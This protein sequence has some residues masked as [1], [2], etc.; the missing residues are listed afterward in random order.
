MKKSKKKILLSAYHY[1]CFFILMAFI[2]TCCMSLFLTTMAKAINLEFSRENIKTAAIYTFFNVVFLSFLCTLIDAIRRKL[3]VDRPVKQIVEAAEKIA[4]GDYSVRIP[5]LKSLNRADGLDQIVNCYNKMAEELAGTETMRTDFI[6][7]VSHELK[8]PLAVMQNY[9]TLLQQENIDEEERLKYAKEITNATRRLADL[10]TN[11]L[12]LNKLENQQIYPDTKRYNLSDQ[13]C[14]CMLNFE[15]IW[16]EKEI[17]IDTDLQDDCYIDA[18]EE[19]LSLVWHNLLSNAFKFTDKGGKV[20]ISLKKQEDKMVIKVMDTG[21]GISKQTGSHIFEK[22]YQGDTS[23][24]TQ[25]NG[26][27]LALVKRVIDIVNGDISVNSKLGVG[28][29][30]I[31]TLKRDSDGEA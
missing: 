10:I 9:G 30:F 18:D 22:F 19:L 6:A 11:I 14:E 1:F 3:T 16:E 20:S 31:V 29:T 17:E 8:T 15:N 21:C 26:L 25:G 4:K 23:R 24:A 12:R 7:N 13:L 28:T 27:G 5:E 2:I